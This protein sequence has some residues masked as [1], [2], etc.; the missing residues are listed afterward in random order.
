[1]RAVRKRVW[2]GVFV[3]SLI[4][5]VRLSVGQSADPDPSAVS[6]GLQQSSLPAG[7]QKIDSGLRE[8]EIAR[9]QYY[10]GYE[11]E[12]Q[13]IQPPYSPQRPAVIR[14]IFGVL[15]DRP[16][17]GAAL[18]C[19][20]RQISRVNRIPENQGQADLYLGDPAAGFVLIQIDRAVFM[21]SL[22]GVA[23]GENVLRGLVSL[24]TEK[25]RQMGI[26]KSLATL[27]VLPT[28]TDKHVRAS[29]LARIRLSVNQPEM[30]P[31][32]YEVIVT[33]HGN[34]MS[35]VLYSQSALPADQNGKLEWTWNGLGDNGSYV[36]NGSYDVTFRALDN[37]GR[38]SGPSVVNINVNR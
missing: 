37:P 8:I 13:S 10:N 28:V 11:Q 12:W 23:D 33:R 4:I 35:G 32:F 15:P 36:P 5:L 18:Y 38:L 24:E 1:M 7:F 16:K 3:T 14:G 9:A 34:N 19:L 20:S 21:L 25:L 26:V 27:A 6:I 17:A 29:S 2:I 22:S 30:G 31:I